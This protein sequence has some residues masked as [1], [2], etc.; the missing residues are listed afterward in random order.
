MG[1]GRA[2][3]NVGDSV[4]NQRESTEKTEITEQT[5]TI[6]LNQNRQHRDN[7][8]PRIFTDA[9]DYGAFHLNR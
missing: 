5:E 3:S 4:D 6:R 2:G 9:T 7:N 1:Q 8:S